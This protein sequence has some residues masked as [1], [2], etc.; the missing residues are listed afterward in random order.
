MSIISDR[1]GDGRAL[2]LK[3]G[4]PFKESALY[5]AATPEADV[6]S[7]ACL[8]A[9]LSGDVGSVHLSTIDST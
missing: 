9:W 4:R 7:T 3:T 1:Y 5:L 8:C 6:V 2:I